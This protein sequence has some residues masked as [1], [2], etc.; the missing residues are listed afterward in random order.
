[1]GL[2]K[3]DAATRVWSLC[4]T[5]SEFRDKLAKYK[6]VPSYVDVAIRLFEAGKME[7]HA[8]AGLLSCA[9]RQE[10][11]GCLDALWTRETRLLATIN[12]MIARAWPHAR[13]KV[14]S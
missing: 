1:L 7:A 8:A 9:S 14:R 2:G 12:L 5:N 10:D 3:A 11:L 13:S 6:A 4:L